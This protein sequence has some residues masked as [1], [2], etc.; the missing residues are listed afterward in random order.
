MRDVRGLLTMH[1]VDR[2]PRTTRLMVML[3]AF[4]SQELFEDNY[5][6]LLGIFNPEGWLET[7]YLD[8]DFRIGRDDKN[9]VF[10][11]QRKS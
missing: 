7:T 1:S 6:M 2:G 10:I 8:D 9:N 11:L 4:C 5:D 3:W